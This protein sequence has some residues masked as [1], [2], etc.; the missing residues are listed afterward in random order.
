[1]CERT[2]YSGLTALLLGLGI[3]GPIGAQVSIL[4]STGS[5]LNTLA[6]PAGNLTTYHFDNLRTGWNANE[7]ILTPTNVNSSSFG[8]LSSAA[9]DA[10]VD[11]QPLVVANQLIKGQSNS[12]EVVYIATESNSIY[13]IAPATGAVLLHVNLGTPVPQSVLPGKC[14][15]NGPNVGINSTPVIDLAAKTMYVI[16]FVLENNQPVYRLHAL[17]LGTLTDKVSPVLVSATHLLD[18]GTMDSFNPTAS[19]QRSALALANGNIYAGFASFCDMRADVSRGW[20]LGWT[21]GQLSP[22]PGNRLDNRHSTAPNNFFL[23]SIW[24]SGYGLA[25]GPSGVLYAATGNSDYSGTTYNT[26]NL[27]ETVLKVSPDL[28]NF[29]DYFTPSTANQL[30]VFDEDLGSGG[31]MV[32][33]DVSGKPSLA[34]AA[35][36]AG[37]MYLINR[38]ALGKY[39]PGGDKVFGTY[40]IGSC[41]CGPSYFVGA[42]GVRRIVSSGGNQAIVWKVATNT[43]S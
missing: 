32:V 24:M 15:N 8:V 19:R 20:L 22:L 31:V 17:D 34:V 37:K 42:D 26:T 33:P 5:P 23:S 27:S 28:N 2:L 1:M 9:L 12:T 36:K 29:I 10:Q 16:N 7:T 14:A 40:D 6:A 39:S 25:V 43:Q 35:G 41:W 18:N 30:D 21:A 3:S 11:A 4:D 13:A 38:S